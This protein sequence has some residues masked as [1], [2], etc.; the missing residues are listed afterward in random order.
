MSSYVGVSGN[1]I[2][3]GS[4][5][6]YGLNTGCKVGLTQRRNGHISYFH[7]EIFCPLRYFIC[8][9]WSPGNVTWS[10]GITGVFLV[11]FGEVMGNHTCITYCPSSE[12]L[13]EMMCE[14]GKL[15]KKCWIKWLFFFKF[16]KNYFWLRWVFVAARGL[17]LVAASG[18]FSLQWLLLCGARA[19]GAQASV[20]VAR[21]LDSC[22]SRAL[23]RRL[24]SCGAWA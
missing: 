18:G 12:H 5:M 13:W 2:S 17:S 15:Y 3:E 10:P 4:L 19:L 24:S 9:Q 1:L 6:E 14:G 20:V 11:Y 7:W 21:R 23:E 22:G 16:F 8:I